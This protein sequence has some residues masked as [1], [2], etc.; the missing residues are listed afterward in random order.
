MRWHK[1][2]QVETEDVLRHPANAEG[3]KHF[4]CEFFYFTSDSWNVRLRLASDGFN[5]FGNMSTLYNMW[6]VVIIPYDFSPWKCMKESNFFISLLIPSPRS[7]GREIDIY[8]QLLIEELKE[9]WTFVVASGINHMSRCFKHCVQRRVPDATSGIPYSRNWNEHVR[10]YLFLTCFNP[11]GNPSFM[12]KECLMHERVP[13]R[14]S[15]D[16]SPDGPICIRRSFPDAFGYICQC[17]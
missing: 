17:F 12:S 6:H 4:D 8:L 9:L 7:P 3:W 15:P 16:S 14:S 5:L 10:S 11:S 13:R 1:D 2:N